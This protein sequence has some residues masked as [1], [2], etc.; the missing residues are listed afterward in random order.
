MLSRKLFLRSKTSFPTLFSSLTVRTGTL[1]P[2]QH[3]IASLTSSSP[4]INLKNSHQRMSANIP[5]DDAMW[6]QFDLD[7]ATKKARTPS[8]PVSQTVEGTDDYN[9][10]EEDAI[11]ASFDLDSSVKQARESISSKTTGTPVHRNINNTSDTSS[12]EHISADNTT[13]TEEEAEAWRSF[14]LEASVLQARS[15]AAN[16]STCITSK[17]PRLSSS[18][19]GN[20]FPNCS[21]SSLQQPLQQVRGL[22]T[23]TTAPL[24]V[25][26]SGS[27]TESNSTSSTYLESV[28]QRYFSFTSFRPGQREVIEAAL[29]GRDSAVVW[30]T[31]KGRFN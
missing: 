11:W 26:P 22:A 25:T 5:N 1:Y 31:G 24:S 9:L 18:S 23:T 28:L 21:S 13:A 10:T 8:K 16:S 12:H 17:K 3:Q 15:P 19:P 4:F 14:D 2:P 27:S 6:L 30:A 29:A 20:V 7:S